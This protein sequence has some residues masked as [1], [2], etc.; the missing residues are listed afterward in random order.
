MFAWIVD[1]NREKI[2]SRIYS[3][4]VAQAR[5]PAFFSHYGVPDT[6]AGRYE[7]MVL[8]VW[9]LLNRFRG[10]DGPGKDAAQA[11][12]DRFFLEMD[13]ALREMGVGDLSVPKKIKTFA[14]IYAARSAAYTAAVDAAD[15]GAL[16]DLVAGA[17]SGGEAAS[18]LAR[19]V[20]RSIAEL[21]SRD[22]MA[23]IEDRVVFPEPLTD[24][25]ER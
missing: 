13:R 15:D 7:L 22:A 6:I 3:E 8:H 1:R 23:L 14:G 21:A 18:G 9:L 24:A 17:L 12:C 10:L 16:T 25:G 4:I 5:H 2:A 11:V 19:Y 20:R